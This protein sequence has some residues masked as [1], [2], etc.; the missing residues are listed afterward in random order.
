MATFVWYNGVMN[1]KPKKMDAI[2]LGRA[3]RKHRDSQNWTLGQLEQRC[4]VA[5]SYLNRLE[6]GEHANVSAKKLAAIASVF[7]LSVDYF[8]EEAGWLPQRED[9]GRLSPAEQRFIE[10]LRAITDAGERQ[11]I[12]DHVMGL[13]R[14]SADVD[15]IVREYRLRKAAEEREEYEQKEE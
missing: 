2:R 5:K 11:E 10:T 1:E 14:F 9:I 7:G 15:G 3:I 12:L 4:G 6:G 13:V 8:C